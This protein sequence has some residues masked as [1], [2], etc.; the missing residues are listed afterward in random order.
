[1]TPQA[2][3]NAALACLE[4]DL[5]RDLE[6]LCRPAA[7]WVPPRQVGGEKVYDIIIIGGGMCGMVAWFALQCEGMLQTRIFDRNPAGLEGPWLNYARMQTL[8]SPKQLVGPAYGMSSLTFRAWF[9]AQFGDSAW[10]LL[11]KIP[12]PMWMEY[13]RWYRKALSVPIEN[14]VNVDGI[15]AEGDLLRLHLSGSGATAA[16]VL[17]RKVVMATGRDGTGHPSIPGFVQGLDR[18]H[19][20]PT[21]CY[22]CRRCCASPRPT[23]DRCSSRCAPSSWAIC[24]S[25]CPR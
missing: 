22:P 13:L 17:T 7:N 9:T 21:T 6:Y 12:R 8:R 20:Q 14:G 1:M 5:A 3:S 11:D 4:R 19:A 2:G 24:S 15:V 10:E 18:S 23:T 16:S 25:R